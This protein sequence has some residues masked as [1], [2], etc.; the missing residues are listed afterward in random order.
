[1]LRQ[2]GQRMKAQPASWK[3]TLR[4]IAVFA[5]LCLTAASIAAAEPP[6]GIQRHLFWKVTG[7]QG[8]VYLFGTI[9]IGKADFYP[10]PQV[11]EDD[12]RQADTLV[13]EVNLDD[14]DE[15]AYVKQWVTEHGSYPAG[16]LVTNHLSDV[17]RS[18]LADYLKKSQQLEALIARMRPWL[19]SVL[20]TELESKRLGLDPSKGLD[21]HFLNEAREQKK[22][23]E[24]LESVGAQLKLFISLP[25]EL[26][27]ELLL[28]SLVDTEKSNELL[29]AVIKAWQ[30]GDAETLQAL[31][32]RTVK[33]YPQL[34]TIMKKLVDDRNDAMTAKIEQLLATP[35]T[36]FI[37][38]GAGHLIGDRGIVSQLRAKPLAVEQQ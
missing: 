38:V 15:I 36:Y 11:V 35:K 20:I 25:Q 23:I 16:D 34:K 17:T 5:P 7:S 21:K 24:T 28:S 14:P 29:D 6:Q 3:A 37:A 26:E 19:I 10:L 8:V 33:D 22:P 9:H 27:D 2:I 13:E 12:F 31:T 4:A 18:H 30:S 1:M 32:D